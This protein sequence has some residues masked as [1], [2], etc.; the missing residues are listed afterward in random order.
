LQLSVARPGQPSTLLRVRPG[1]RFDTARGTRLSWTDL[2]GRLT[3]AR[4]VFVGE[5]HDHRG[6]HR[7]QTAVISRLAQGERPLLVGMEMF[8]R[9]H[10]PAVFKKWAA[11]QLT[12]KRFI[13]EVDW[14]RQWGMR[15]GYYRPLFQAAQ[16]HRLPIVGLNV[17][18]QIA[19]TVGRR[20]LAALTPAVRATLPRLHLAFNRHRQVFRALLGLGPRSAKR[21][22][23]HPM[24][25]PKAA[26]HPAARPVR[27]HG[28]GHGR[29]GFMDRL[30][31]AQVLRD[32]VMAAEIVKALDRAGPRS[33]MVVIVG[34]GHLV[35]HTGVNNRLRR[36]R[37]AWSQATVICVSANPAGRR[38]SRGLGDYLIATPRRR[39]HPHPRRQP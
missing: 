3:R 13:Q 22:R 12:E 9:D 25:H 36:L 38:V 29:P 35:Y 2:T 4:V 7:I 18:I 5:R 39:P 27:G 34:N 32:E 15:F 21:P 33:R 17:P 30:F 31:T 8:H 26:P 6:H 14:R 1:D 11:S 20:G 24:G 19:R 37:P 16:K 10:A 28:H 23:T